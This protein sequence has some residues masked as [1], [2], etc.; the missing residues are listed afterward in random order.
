MTK[1]I[2]I[3]TKTIIFITVFVAVIW[4][5][6]Q[7]K[8]ILLG[9][10]IALILMSCINPAVRKLERFKLPR[11]LA[12]L[13]IYIFVIL[14]I[15]LS[16]GWLVPPLIEQTTIFI[17]N[18]PA[19]FQQ[20]KIFGIDEKLIASQFAQ[21][22]S[23][24]INLVKFLFDIFS[25]IAAIIALG[26]ITFYL[27][28]ERKNL[29]RYLSLVLGVEKEKKIEI[30]INLIET[31]LGNWVRGEL[32]LMMFVGTISYL[33]FLVIGIDYALPLALLAFLF[34]IIPNVGPTMAAIPAVIVGLTISPFHGLATAG[35]C[36]LVQQIENGILVPRIMKKVAG[37]N[38]L[39]SLLSLAVGF[40]LAGIGGAILAIPSYIIVEVIFSVLYP[41]RFKQTDVGSS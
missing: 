3:S 14:I 9:L 24:P 15:G 27:L 12:I 17:N 13:F 23:I 34:E 26:V 7:I 4:F 31:R 18:I 35:W 22:S 29:D 5:I 32:L 25:N 40:K 30:I 37:V 39:V 21:F 2:E 41:N 16:L 20:F 33:G 11:W 38:P 28:L 1:K 8:D 10:F 19:F 36:F 6:F